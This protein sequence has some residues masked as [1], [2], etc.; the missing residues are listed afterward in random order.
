MVSDSPGD[1]K[2]RSAISAFRR[3]SAR[4][5][6]ISSSRRRELGWIVACASVW[7]AWHADD[8]DLA[9]ASRHDRC[10]GERPEFAAGR[11][12]IGAARP[13]CRSERTTL[14]LRMRIPARPSV[15]R[16]RVAGLPTRGSTGRGSALRALLR[17]RPVA[18]S[19]PTGPRPNRRRARGRAR[20]QV[21]WLLPSPCG[22]RGARPPRPLR[23]RQGR[24]GAARPW[25]RQAPGLRRVARAPGGLLFGRGGGRAPRARESEASWR[26]EVLA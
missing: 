10:G 8:T 2:S 5:R 23:Q 25:A 4:S 9:H 16:R 17:N 20:V 6:M 22:R 21:R 14:R 7:S 18:T 13:R 3:P 15:G 24:C 11:C 26:C 12:G 1:R 19:T